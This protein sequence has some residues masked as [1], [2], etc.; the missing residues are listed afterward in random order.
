MEVLAG[1]SA[2]NNVGNILLS[3][4]IT[5]SAILKIASPWRVGIRFPWQVQKTHDSW[6]PGGRNELQEPG[7]SHIIAHHRLNRFCLFAGERMEKWSQGI[8]ASLGFDQQGWRGWM[9]GSSMYGF[10]EC[11]CRQAKFHFGCSHHVN[12]F[13]GPLKW[14]LVFCKDESVWTPTD[15]S[16]VSRAQDIVTKPALPHSCLGSVLSSKLWPVSLLP[17][18]VCALQLSTVGTFEGVPPGAIHLEAWQT[19]FYSSFFLNATNKH[20][21]VE[22]NYTIWVC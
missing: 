4:A 3:K 14:R 11:C 6:M 13:S 7:E 12:M 22:M 1:P 20:G 16:A 8:S 9:L 21:H 18:P 19:C 15:C 17:H 10:R 2:I 5:G